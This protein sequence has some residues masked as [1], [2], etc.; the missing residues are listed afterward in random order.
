M[1]AAMSPNR[2]SNPVQNRA[3]PVQNQANF[4]QNRAAPVQNQANLVQNQANPVQNQDNP[5]QNAVLLLS[6]TNSSC[7]L[8]F[9]VQWHILWLKL[10]SVL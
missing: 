1:L 9:H 3:N 5:V 7:I 8:A 4:V 6:N 10:S 2:S